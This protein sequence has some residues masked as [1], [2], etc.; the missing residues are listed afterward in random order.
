MAGGRPHFCEQ[1][2]RGAERL[3]TELKD[4]L[5]EIRATQLEIL[6]KTIALESRPLP[7]CQE[8]QA[9][10]EKLKTAA[11]FAGGRWSVITAL[12]T[13]V[14]SLIFSVTSLVTVYLIKKHLPGGGGD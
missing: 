4:D 12:S 5:K 2:Q 6:K 1:V 10:V 8:M 13:Q 3:H 7:P 11:T 9:R 14:L